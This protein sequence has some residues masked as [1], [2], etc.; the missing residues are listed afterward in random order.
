MVHDGEDEVCK[1]GGRSWIQVEA[2]A[3]KDVP[4]DM[5]MD[6]R[7]TNAVDQ[8]HHHVETQHHTACV[9]NADELLE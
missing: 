5:V 7:S 2:N 1:N 3:E 6:Q 4:H 8:V 9:S